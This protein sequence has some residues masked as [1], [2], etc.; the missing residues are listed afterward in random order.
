MCSNV[1]CLLAPSL[2]KNTLKSNKIYTS[3][4]HK[5]TL[6]YRKRHFLL[7]TED[8]IT[9][10]PCAVNNCAV[11]VVPEIQGNPHAQSSADIEQNT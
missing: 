10:Q 6:F 8:A 3:C 9:L 11:I 2:Y 7:C 4:Y 1:Y 5:S